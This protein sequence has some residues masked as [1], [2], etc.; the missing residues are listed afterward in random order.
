GP[1]GIGRMCWGGG[2]VLPS[3]LYVA[4]AERRRNLARRALEA[5]FRAVT[6]HGAGGIWLDTYWTWQ[7]A[8]R[9]YARI[10]MWVWM[11]KHNLVFT[12]QEDLPPYRV[13]IE[14]SDARF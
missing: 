4:P 7:P 5:V 14:G 3:S 10:G 11:W 6:A 8:V 2:L 1:R 13:E 12:W 9:F